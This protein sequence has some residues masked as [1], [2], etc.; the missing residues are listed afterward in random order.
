[1]E[2]FSEILFKTQSNKLHTS[3]TYNNNFRKQ[4]TK[5]EKETNINSKNYNSNSNLDC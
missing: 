1:M 3:S 4:L 2:I 5:K